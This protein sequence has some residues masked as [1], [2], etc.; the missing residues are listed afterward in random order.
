MPYIYLISSIVFAASESIMGAFYN[1]KNLGRKE[2]SSLYSLLSM[3]SVF[4]FWAI[5]FARDSSLDLYV[6]PYALG[7]AFFYALCS[8]CLIRALKTGPITLTSLFMQ[9]SLVGT[10]IWGF[11]F[12]DSKFTL[13][14]AIGLIL[15]V[16]ALWLCLYQG[17]S[18]EENGKISAK[19]LIY[20]LLAFVANAGCS[21]IQRT[22]Q[23]NFNG[24]YGNFLMLIATAISVV[25][26]LITYLKNDR[27]DSKII[28]RDSWYI[29]VVAGGM[30]GLLNL[31]VILLATST[32]SP[33]L[34]Y[35]VISVGSL[36]LTTICSAC[37]FKEKMPWWQWVGVGVG[38]VAVALLSA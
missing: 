34:I 26:C 11:L 15:V 17:K 22:Q 21:I 19:W 32:L 25:I 12:W 36:A 16:V 9:L 29:P 8:I 7:F 4:I 6:I 30:N 23:V 13:L 2:S 18:K 35:P 27:S 20:A 5:L 33:S 38:A 10:T 1:Q 28:L 37:I 24:N 31:F 14:I 3:C